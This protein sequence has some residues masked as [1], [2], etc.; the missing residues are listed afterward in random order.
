MRW[1]SIKP[2]TMRLRYSCELL[3]YKSCASL[4][5]SV[6]VP[7]QGVLVSLLERNTHVNIVNHPVLVPE[8]PTC[9]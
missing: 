1:Y 3:K 6:C 7:L 9:T 5:S 4:L 2:E 8:P